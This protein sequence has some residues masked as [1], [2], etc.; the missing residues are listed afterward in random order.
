MLVAFK[1]IILNSFDARI[2]GKVQFC[3]LYETSLQ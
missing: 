1:K 2:I 3:Y